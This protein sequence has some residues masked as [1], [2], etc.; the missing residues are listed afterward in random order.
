[1]LLRVV[2][3]LAILL[4]TVSSLAWYRLGLREYVRVLRYIAQIDTVVRPATAEK[5]DGR[6]ADSVYG[7]ILAGIYFD[8][9]WL[10]SSEG[11]KHYPLTDGGS[12]YTYFSMCYEENRAKLAQGDVNLAIRRLNTTADQRIWRG[13]SGDYVRVEL[14]GEEVREV[15]GFDWW[16]FAQQPMREVC[17]D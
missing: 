2:L 8:Q 9:I 4:V 16:V 10:W 3:V 12:S 11:L 6:S 7:G 13:K 17:R 14:D 1:M 5:F 15:H